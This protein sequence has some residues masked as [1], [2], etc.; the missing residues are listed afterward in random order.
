[1]PA[2]A[3]ERTEAATRRGGAAKDATPGNWRD[4][5]IAPTRRDLPA[6]VRHA[7]RSNASQVLRRVRGDSAAYNK[8]STTPVYTWHIKVAWLRL[9]AASP[10]HEGYITASTTYARASTRTLF[11]W[12]RGRGRRT[13]CDADKPVV[14]RAEPRMLMKMRRKFRFV[15][16]HAG[17][18]GCA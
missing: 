14:R 16:Y 10:S 13:S 6:E 3:Q 18:G 4:L 8:P 17:G 5:Y 11:K 2:V 9:L 1:M 12:P 7:H 15:C